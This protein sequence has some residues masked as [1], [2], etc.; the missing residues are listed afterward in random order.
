MGFILKRLFGYR[1]FRIIVPLLDLFL[2]YAANIVAFYI[3]KDD[4][5]NFTANYNAFKGVLPYVLIGYFILSQIFELHKPKDFTF[6]GISYTVVLTIL[7]L[8]FVTM[9]ISFLSREFAYP[10]SILLTAAGLQVV[11]ISFWHLFLL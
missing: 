7:S 8:L 5:N 4:L 3:L 9:A 10:R 2:V 11:F 6:F 1:G